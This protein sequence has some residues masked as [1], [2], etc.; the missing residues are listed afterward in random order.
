MTQT[1]MSISTE[2][3]KTQARVLTPPNV[4]YRNGDVEVCLIVGCLHRNLTHLLEFEVETSGLMECREER[5]QIPRDRESERLGYSVLRAEV[6]GRRCVSTHSWLVSKSC[7]FRYVCY[8]L[9]KLRTI[10]T[11]L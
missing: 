7:R 6:F 1:G 11:H 9:S 10:L 3:M 2:L 4:E 5:S 8:H